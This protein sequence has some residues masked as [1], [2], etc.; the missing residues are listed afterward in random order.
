MPGLYVYAL[1][2]APR[3]TKGRPPS[4]RRG[5]AHGRLTGVFG[6]PLRTIAAGGGVY[7]IVEDAARAP[8]ATLGRLRDQD[9]VLRALATDGRA[10]LPARFGSFARDVRELKAML[11]GRA[12]GLI[13]LLKQVRGCEQMTLRLVFEASEPRMGQAAFPADGG[14][15]TD[16]LRSLLAQER[17]RRAHP[18]FQAVRRAA[19]GLARAERVEWHSGP[20]RAA[21]V[22]HLVPRARLQRY[23]GKIAAAARRKDATLVVSGPFLPFAFAGELW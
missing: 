21:S 7:A 14:T 22:Y 16:Y 12:P 8:K 17:A 20:G 13:R 23:L 5:S 11:A 15:G 4:G 6:R 18:A 3:R 2:D 9:R 1:T 10:L 19:R